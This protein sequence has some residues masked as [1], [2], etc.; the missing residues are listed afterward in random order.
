MNFIK[1]QSVSTWLVCATFVLT[2]LGVIMYGANVGNLGYFHKIPAGNLVVCSVFA[3]IFEV[4]VLAVAQFEFKGIV[5]IVVNT[6]AAAAKIVV[7]A[8]LAVA[9]MAFVATRMEGFGF[10][11]FCDE[12]VKAT[13][14]TAENMSSVATAITGFVFYGLAMVTG[15]VAAFFSFKKKA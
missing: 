6:L 13:M 12:N 15:C 3:L 5:G 14:Q 1:K 10:I 8:I 9:L 2:L 4:A 11:L 7:P